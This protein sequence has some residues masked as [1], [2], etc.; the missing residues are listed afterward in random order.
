MSDTEQDAVSALLQQFPNA[1]RDDRAL[2]EQLRAV[3]AFIQTPGAAFEYPLAPQGTPFQQQVWRAL[4]KIPVGQTVSYVQL[5]QRI[6]APGSA[7]AVAQACGAN[8]IAV[9][10]PCHRA[11]RADGGLS[12]YRWGT[13]RKQALLE[14]EQ[15]QLQLLR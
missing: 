10:I 12:G 14:R 11:V 13:W 1:Q 9:L 15:R 7:R 2:S 4:E 5:A 8:S 6:G 3:V